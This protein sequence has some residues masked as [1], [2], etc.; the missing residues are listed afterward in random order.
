MN[1]DEKQMRKEEISIHSRDF[2]T[3]QSRKKERKKYFI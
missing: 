2:E 1:H 3:K